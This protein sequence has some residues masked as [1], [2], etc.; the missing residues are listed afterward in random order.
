MNG[1][2]DFFALGFWFAAGAAGF[3]VCLFVGAAAALAFV[4][5]LLKQRR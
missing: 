2:L 5:Y 3:L 4:G 1:A